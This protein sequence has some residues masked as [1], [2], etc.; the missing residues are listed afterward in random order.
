MSLQNNNKIVPKNIQ[1]DEENQTESLS[2]EDSF[3]DQSLESE[4]DCYEEDG[5]IIMEKQDQQKSFDKISCE[6]MREKK[7]N[8]N[9]CCRRT[10]EKTEDYFQMKLRIKELQIRKLMMKS[11]KS[12]KINKL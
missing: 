5:F 12:K 7:N 1:N 9:K 2:S 11:K 8:Q 4:N 10:S 3:S 6:Y